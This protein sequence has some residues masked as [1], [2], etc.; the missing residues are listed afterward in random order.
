MD[1]VD[2]AS[3]HVSDRGSKERFTECFGENIGCGCFD[4][5]VLRERTKLNAMATTCSVEMKN[6]GV[7]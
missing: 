3:H 2:N 1:Q 6:R 7:F 5:M 4:L